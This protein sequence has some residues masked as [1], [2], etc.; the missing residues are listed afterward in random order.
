MTLI[1]A[2][3]DGYDSLVSLTDADQYHVKMG[4]ARWSG[5]G[6]EAALR[7]G[8]QYLLKH[9]TIKSASLDP[10]HKDVAEA[11]CE[12]ALRALTGELYSDVEAQA[13]VEETVGPLTTRYSDPRNGGQKRFAI[14]EDLLSEHVSGAGQIRL[15]RA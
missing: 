8:T 3:A 6:R 1:V 2:P 14:I 7:R 10:V 4:H 13:I 12:A 11:C 9:F 15:V 5:S